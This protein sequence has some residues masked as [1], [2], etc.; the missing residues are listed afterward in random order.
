MSVVSNVISD[1]EKSCYV[2][3][4]YH[5]GEFN[6]CNVSMVGVHIYATQP[7]LSSNL[8]SRTI[9]SSIDPPVLFLDFSRGFRSSFALSVGF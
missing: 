2:C 9:A 1:V 3:A 4:V 8:Q 5:I 7:Q 6:H